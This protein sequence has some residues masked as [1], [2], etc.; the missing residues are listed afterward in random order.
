MTVDEPDARIAARDELIAHWTELLGGEA[1]PDGTYSIPRGCVWPNDQFL[2]LALRLVS[3]E[4]IKHAM[5]QATLRGNG[6][7]RTLAAFYHRTLEAVR[8]HEHQSQPKAEMPWPAL[9]NAIAHVEQLSEGELHLAKYPDAHP[10]RRWQAWIGS[11]RGSPDFKG[12][13][14]SDPFMA[15]V[16]LEIAIEDPEP[17][18]ESGE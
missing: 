7:P 12:L 8:A 9:G 14:S 2:Y 10:G 17:G 13:G 5:E 6:D 11:D 16:N 4:E 3:C 15:V 1:K 18:P